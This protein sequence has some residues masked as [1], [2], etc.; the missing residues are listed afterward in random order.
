MITSEFFH[1]CVPLMHCSHSDQ[2]QEHFWCLLQHPTGNTP[3]FLNKLNWSIKFPI[4]KIIISKLFMCKRHTLMD[5][6]DFF[7]KKKKVCALNFSEQAYW[8]SWPIICWIEWSSIKYNNCKAFSW[9]ANRF[10]LEQSLGGKIELHHTTQI[11]T[12]YIHPW[13]CLV[14]VKGEKNQ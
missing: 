8:R 14:T 13:Q 9:C 7:F 11:D 10:L 4:K 6:F 12:T 3:L 1:W 5:N 2:C